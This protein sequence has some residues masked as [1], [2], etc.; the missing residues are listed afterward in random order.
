MKKNKMI[1]KNH[2]PNFYKIINFGFL[3]DDNISLRLIQVYKNFVFSINPENRHDLKMVGRLD[4]VINK[5]IED[6]YV[7]QEMQKG[8]E[9][10]KTK[11]SGDI[12]R[13]AVEGVLR[14][15]DRY[16]NSFTRVISFA[17]WI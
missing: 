14:S 1:L 9:E 8:M 17:R 15:F 4:F 5:Y 7:R 12:I 10:I 11:Q 3:E 2:C 6:Y 13:N 16:E